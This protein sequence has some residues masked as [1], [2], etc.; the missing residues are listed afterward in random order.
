MLV[1]R[2]MR[3]VAEHRTAAREGLPVKQFGAV[4]PET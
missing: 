3:D 2:R 1:A 4:L